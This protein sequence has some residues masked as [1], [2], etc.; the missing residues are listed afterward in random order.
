MVEVKEGK[1]EDAKTKALIEALTSD[2]VK[3]Y[4]EQTYE[5]AVVPLF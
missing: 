4:M 5:G 1:E 3:E 2:V